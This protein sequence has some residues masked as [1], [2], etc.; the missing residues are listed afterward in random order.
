MV[1]K[2][3]PGEL[4]PASEHKEYQVGWEDLPLSCPTAGMKMWNAHPR[5]YLPIHRSGRETCSYCGSTYVLRDPSPDQP[6]PVFDNAEIEMAFRR[7][8]ERVRKQG[9]S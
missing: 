5:S 7:A 9:E 1:A 3:K 6:M 8:Q 2:R 4:G